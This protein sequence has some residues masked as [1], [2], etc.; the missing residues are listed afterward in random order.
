MSDPTRVA[1]LARVQERLCYTFRDLTLLDCA[2]THKSYANE[3]GCS[4]HYERLEFLG[5][6]VLGLII[7]AYLYTQ[8]PASREGELSKLRARVVSAD[9]LAAF[10]RE[11]DLGAA[12]QLGRGEQHSGGREKNSLLAAALE[13]VVAALYLDGGLA[14]AQESFLWCFGEMM[15]Q[16]VTSTQGWDYKGMLQEYTLSVFGCTP[17]YCVVDEE[18]PPHQKIFHVQLTLNQE[19]DCLGIGPSKK[20]AEQHAAQQLFTLLQPDRSRP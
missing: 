14:Q 6:A 1:C 20:A 7:S 11:I 18:G 16:Y 4:Q 19:Y 10:A 8:Y 13:A 9:S 5:D 2:L 3:V 15:T 17:M 12:L